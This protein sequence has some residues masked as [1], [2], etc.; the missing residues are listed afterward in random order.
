MKCQIPPFTLVSLFKYESTRSAIYY[1]TSLFIN[2]MRC[3]MTARVVEA[4][5]TISKPCIVPFV[6]FRT[7]QLKRYVI[8]QIMPQQAHDLQFIQ[9]IKD[10]VVGFLISPVTG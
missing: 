9:R 4:F 7:I 10:G 8:H 2:A 6:S 3:S 1:D 5:V